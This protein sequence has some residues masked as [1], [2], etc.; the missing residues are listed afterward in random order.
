MGDG[1][2]DKAAEAA[3]DLD[4]LLSAWYL[5]CPAAPSSEL[6]GRFARIKARLST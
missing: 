2:R 4:S 5:A 6:D 1:E 3:T